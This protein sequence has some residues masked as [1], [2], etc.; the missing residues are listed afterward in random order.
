MYPRLRQR[1]PSYDTS[2]IHH[3]STNN[4]T[5]NTT[6]A[7]IAFST[8]RLD[9]LPAEIL[10]QI[11]N[12][13]FV[14]RLDD[15]GFDVY[16]SNP[17]DY[18]SRKVLERLADDPR[19][20]LLVRH[21]ALEQRYH[22]LSP[23]IPCHYRHAII[24]LM[25]MA[26]ELKTN[27]DVGRSVRLLHLRRAAQCDE[28]YKIDEHRGLNG[29][30][31]PDGLG[32]RQDGARVMAGVLDLLTTMP[33]VTRLVSAVPGLGEVPALAEFPLVLPRLRRLELHELAYFDGGSR[34]LD[35]NGALLQ[36]APNLVALQL[37]FFTR[38][39]SSSLSSSSSS[40]MSSSPSPSPRLP[41]LQWI[42][43]DM[44]YMPAASMLQVVALAGP[45]L[46]SVTADL[47]RRTCRPSDETGANVSHMFTTHDLLTALA[48]WQA[49]S[50]TKLSLG[51]AYFVSHETSDIDHE[52]EDKHI[53]H[54]D[55]LS[56]M[57]LLPQFTALC[58]LTISIDLLDWRT[59]DESD[60]HLTTTYA[61]AD[62]LVAQLPPNLTTLII[63]PGLWED[64]EFDHYNQYELEDDD[65][66]GMLH[67]W[68]PRRQ[69]LAQALL[70]ATRAGRFPRL[71]SISLLPNDIQQEKYEVTVKNADGT[72]VTRTI[73]LIARFASQLLAANETDRTTILRGKNG[74]NR[75]IR[76]HLE[77]QRHAGEDAE[78]DD[79][80][81]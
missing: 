32:N 6:M 18:D 81:D 47:M 28:D 14:G 72:P 52:D 78:V 62:A 57:T 46:Q 12:C 71:T 69:A 73:E 24:N 79:D 67:G 23:M 61:V 33:L 66:T 63:A 35:T 49:T 48:P 76:R 45:R 5:Q 55:G 7:P 60:R 51:R 53:A 8:S 64:D 9:M 31:T 3:P 80:E 77:L 36:A 74:L 40:A 70:A 39:V 44:C 27:P 29:S 68:W 16:D 22:I 42:N 26:R 59:A 19:N 58:D 50:L 41:D 11:F 2:I 37:F 4:S 15:A 38:V 43:L 65:G 34:I 56:V 54:R 1:R 10:R 20:S 13:A 30:G 17:L 75:Y 25:S 21:L